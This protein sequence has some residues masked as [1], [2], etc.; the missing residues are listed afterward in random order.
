MNMVI[1]TMIRHRIDYGQPEA[2][3]FKVVLSYIPQLWSSLQNSGNSWVS[4]AT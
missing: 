3:G 2:L 1:L 4:P